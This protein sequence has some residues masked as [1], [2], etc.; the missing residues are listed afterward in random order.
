LRNVAYLSGCIY[1]ALEIFATVGLP[2]RIEIDMT[3]VTVN[4]PRDVQVGM[5]AER[6]NVYTLSREAP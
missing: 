1:Q 6:L 4:K 3:E 2:A 5:E